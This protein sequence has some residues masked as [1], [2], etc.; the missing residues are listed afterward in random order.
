MSPLHSS[1]TADQTYPTVTAVSIA[2]TATPTITSR[3][4]TRS[5]LVV[6]NAGS[7]TAPG[8]AAAASKSRRRWHGEFKR[9]VSAT[10]EVA[11]CLREKGLRRLV[12]MLQV[13]DSVLA[14]RPGRCSERDA[15]GEEC[16]R[17]VQ[18]TPCDQCRCDPSDICEAMVTTSFAVLQICLCSE[19][20][21]YSAWVILNFQVFE[22]ST[23]SATLATGNVV[24]Q[25]FNLCRRSYCCRQ[26]L[27]R[28]FWYYLQSL[29]LSI[30]QRLLCTITSY[31]DKGCK[32][33]Q[34]CFGPT[35]H[36]SAKRPCAYISLYDTMS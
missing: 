22:V 35:L 36:C 4:P 21:E 28:V 19:D 2:P 30:R 23:K 29:K 15:P 10:P 13:H 27:G 14:R 7:S 26:R 24:F 1:L 12:T 34:A 31:Y 8:A 17:A 20:R 33:G 5:I 9:Q 11:F 25:A 3:L 6:S 32:S 18:V 16:V